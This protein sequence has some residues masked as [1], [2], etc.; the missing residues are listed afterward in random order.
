MRPYYYRKWAENPPPASSTSAAPAGPTGPAAQSTIQLVKEWIT[1][2][3]PIL[4]AALG[5]GVGG[6]VAG[7]YFTPK[8]YKGWGAAGGALG[9]AGLGAGLAA[10]IGK[11]FSSGTGTAENKGKTG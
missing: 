11:A 6:G 8:G 10:L 2:N 1:A 5:G 4:L 7:Y 3:W 9:G